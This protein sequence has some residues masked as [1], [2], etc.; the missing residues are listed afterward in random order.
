MLG[1]GIFKPKSHSFVFELM[2]YS[3]KNLKKAI[4]RKK[5]KKM[6]NF[7]VIFA[8]VHSQQRVDWDGMNLMLIQEIVGY[9]PSHFN[10]PTDGVVIK[11]LFVIHAVK[12]IHNLRTAQSN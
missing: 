6:K 5:T 11:I 9:V 4:P 10:F 1:Y 3:F 12:S 2:L 8:T 7:H